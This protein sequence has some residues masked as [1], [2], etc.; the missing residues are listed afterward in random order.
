MHNVCILGSALFFCKPFSYRDIMST[1]EPLLSA[2]LV[3]IL[4]SDKGYRI[5]DTLE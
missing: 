2:M 3:I 1:S 4:S 5:V